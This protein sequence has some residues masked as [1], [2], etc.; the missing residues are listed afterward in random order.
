MI[1]VQL[2]QCLPPYIHSESQ[3]RTFLSTGLVGPSLELI[4]ARVIASLKPVLR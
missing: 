4:P 2:V 1:K 3:A